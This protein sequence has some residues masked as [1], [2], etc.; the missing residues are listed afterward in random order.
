MFRRLRFS[1]LNQRC[2]RQRQ[3]ARSLIRMLWVVPPRNSEHA[4]GGETGNEP[5]PAVHRVQWV[6]GN[7]ERSG[8]CPCPAVDHTHL[9]KIELFV[10]SCKPAAR[11]IDSEPQPGNLPGA[12]KVAVV[13]SEQAHENG[14]VVYARNISEPE[15]ACGQEISTA[16][17]SDDGGPSL[18]SDEIGECSCIKPKKI[19]LTWIATEP[20]HRRIRF[21]IY[22]HQPLIQLNVR[23]DL[24]C[25]EQEGI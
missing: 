4:V 14:V 9:N 6:R 24:G 22:S 8:R 21:C 20:V 1:H 17:N 7:R 18:M 10:A 13:V 25:A 19:H 12:A 3:D 5:L 23:R 16:A 11:V 2:H 15:N